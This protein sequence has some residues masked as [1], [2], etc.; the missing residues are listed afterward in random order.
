M[1]D[2]FIRVGDAFSQL[3]NTVFLLSDNPNESISGRAYRCSSDVY[4][5]KAEKCINFIFQAWEQDHCKKAFLKDLERAR[6]LIYQ[7]DT[8]Q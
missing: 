8:G 6:N 5:G 3:I 7:E 4:W 2:Y 1:L